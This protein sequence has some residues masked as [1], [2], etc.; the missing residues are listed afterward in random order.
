MQSRQWPHATGGEQAGFEEHP[1]ET[2]RLHSSLRGGPFEGN[3]SAVP[4]AE[5]TRACAEGVQDQYGRMQQP[6]THGAAEQDQQQQRHPAWIVSRL[7]DQGLGEA[8]VGDQTQTKDR[9]ENPAQ[10]VSGGGQVTNARVGEGDQHGD[11]RTRQHEP[12]DRNECAASTAQVPADQQAHR[13]QV[14]AGRELAHGEQPRVLGGSDPS[15]ALHEGHVDHVQDADATT[16]RGGTDA[17]PFAEQVEKAWLE[18]IWLGRRL[19]WFA[20]DHQALIPTRFD[21]RLHVMLESRAS[22]SVQTVQAVVLPI[23]IGGY[24]LLS[25][26]CRLTLPRINPRDSCFI[27]SYPETGFY[28]C[29]TSV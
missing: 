28:R 8:P 2:E 10:G 15:V 3:P 26:D 14:D 11:C 9:G 21:V 23:H 17:E 25:L 6:V 27:A 4:R 20:G 19:C 12:E 1:E 16:E 13:Q 22:R 24:F 29:S 18:F 5:R 7:H